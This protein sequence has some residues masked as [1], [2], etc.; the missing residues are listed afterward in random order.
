VSII[1][2]ELVLEEADELAAAPVG[3]ETPIA[4]VLT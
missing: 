4:E 2:D 3:K 1:E